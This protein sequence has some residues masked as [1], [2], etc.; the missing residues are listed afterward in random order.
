M[1]F[2]R[3]LEGNSDDPLYPTMREGVPRLAAHA[4]RIID[5]E[6]PL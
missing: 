6:Q 2:R 3:H 5:G 1:F 4:M